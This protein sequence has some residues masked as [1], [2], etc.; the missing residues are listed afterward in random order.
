[1]YNVM[2]GVDGSV[3]KFNASFVAKGFSQIEGI[4]YE[5]T[6]SRVAQYSSIRKILALAAHMGQKIHQMDVK[7]IF[8]NGVVEEEIYME[9]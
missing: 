2:H 8:L 7:K 1:M 5:E 9:K 3:E 4:D 6:F